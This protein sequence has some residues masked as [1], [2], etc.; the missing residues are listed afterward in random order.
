MRANLE[1]TNLLFKTN[2]QTT[3]NSNGQGGDERHNIVEDGR[4]HSGEAE[5]ADLVRE[6]L[7]T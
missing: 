2:K 3:S 1:R 6:R 7:Q 5:I 4:M